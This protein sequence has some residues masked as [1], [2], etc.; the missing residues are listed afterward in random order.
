MTSSVWPLALIGMA[1][2]A[3]Y[4]NAL[5]HPFIFDDSLSI[6]DN[7]SIR[8]VGTSLLGGPS[9]LPTAGRPLV[10]VSFA[11]NYAVGGLDPWGY[12]AVNL[13]LH[14]AC[15]ML[16]FALLRRLLEG[17]VATGLAAYVATIWM[18]HPLNS[19]VVNYAT[20]RTEAMMALAFLTTLY[21][22]VRGLGAHRPHGW[23]VL[24]VTA[25]AGGMACKESMITAPVMMLLLDATLMSGT[26]VTALRR[27]PRYYAALFASWT[28]LAALM[29]E[30][31][32]WHSAGFSSGVS[33]W[34]YLLNQPPLIT[35][36]LGLSFWPGSL[37]LDYGEPAAT[38][39]SAVAPSFIFV[40]L[41]VIATLVAWLRIPTLAVAGTWFWITLAPT[42]SI[43]PIATEAGAE[44]RMYLPLIA[45]IVI[46]VFAARALVRLIGSDRVR[47]LVLRSAA[48][49]A[50]CALAAT[51]VHRNSEYRT[52]LHIWQTV[53]DRYP[54]GRAHYNLGLELKAA[55][56]RR[57]ALAQYRVGLATSADAHY[58]M[59]FELD[60]DGHHEEAIAEYQTYIAMKPSDVNVPRAYHQIGR[61]LMAL[62][63]RDAAIAAFGEVL[64]RKP[65]DV[66][67]V[68]GIAD[69]QMAAERWADAARSYAQYI[70]LNPTS[71]AP[72]LN[73]GLSL[74]RL[75]RFDDAVQVFRDLVA[76]NPRMVAARVNLGTALAS[77]RRYDEAVRVLTQAQQIESDPDGRRAITAMI[78]ELQQ[79]R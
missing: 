75:E 9:Q 14:I 10:N 20:Q 17:A 41:L 57:D 45:I 39:F 43:V 58:A 22:G 64:A 15:G 56:R 42:S 11:L 78:E 34:V 48:T 19:E 24:S 73:L 31:P 25:C 79:G 21:A 76:L 62:G 12:H 36:Y 71:D 49:V 51:T 67:A 66:D 69:T 3:A 2:V 65:R 35:R 44:R 32:R 33:P 46:A 68:A 1:G 59:G 29:V 13:L 16:L 26:I 61:A 8:T 60:E 77:L 5:G 4:A 52:P 38:T 54:T 6:I 27:R 28:V 70:A 40:T 47:R 7:P 50:V 18:V 74:L 63:R 37:V 23:D 55:G 72:R 53:V 30:G